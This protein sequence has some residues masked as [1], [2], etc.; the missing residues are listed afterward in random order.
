MIGQRARFGLRRLVHVAVLAGF[1]LLQACGSSGP[2]KPDDAALNIKPGYKVGRPYIIMG[3]RYTPQE[4]FSW[5]ETG[6]ASWYGPGFHARLTANG[7]KYDQRA[8]TA[9]HRTLQLPSV[10]RVT[11]LENGRSVIVRVNDRGP[12]HDNRI[13]DL[14]EAGAEALDFRH[15][16][17]ARVEVTVLPGPSHKIARMARARE[18]VGA[19]DAYI[20]ALNADPPDDV[21]AARQPLTETAPPGWFLQAAAY[22]NPQNADRARSRLSAV[23]GAQVLETAAGG[24]SLYLV[25]VGPYATKSQ[26]QDAL[27]LVQ[28]E[29]FNDAL[30]VKSS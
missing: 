1:G 3:K 22:A 24:R 10:V 28:R 15:K 2:E 23:G 16:G 26:A 21:A 19:M 14:S 29:G 8:F 6:I 5:R 13:I 18:T 27:H 7:E 17:L 11:H 12:F 4:S 9:A 30:L 20:A 25:R